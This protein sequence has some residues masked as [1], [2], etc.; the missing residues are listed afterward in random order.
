MHEVCLSALDGYNV[1]AIAYGQTGSGKTNTILGDITTQNQEISIENHGLQLQVMKQLFSV[2]EHRS[3]RFK[4][5]FSLTIVEVY[6]ERLA[7]LLAST[8]ASARGHVVL[9]DSKRKSQRS[10]EDDTTSSRP[11]K[12]EILTD[13]H[14]VTVMQG[15]VSLEI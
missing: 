4:D 11:A 12:L 2:A 9:A 10:L 13:V 3:D 14:G 6:N 15:A 7:D 8:Q 5:V 1:C